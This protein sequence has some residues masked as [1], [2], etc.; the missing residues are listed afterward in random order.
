ML[1]VPHNRLRNPFISQQIIWQKLDGKTVSV[2]LGESPQPSYEWTCLAIQRIRVAS[3]RTGH[4]E[5]HAVRRA[6]VLVVRATL[7]FLRASGEGFLVLA[8]AG[9]V[10]LAAF[11]LVF[12][13]ALGFLRASG[14]G[15]IVF[16]TWVFLASPTTSTR[17]GNSS[18]GGFGVRWWPWCSDWMWAASSSVRSSV[19]ARF[20]R[21][22]SRYSGIV[23]VAMA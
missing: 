7:G 13:A 9:F 5:C 12:R 2:K 23:L 8:A 19:S 22:S 11:A 18:V 17:A 15:F 3:I 6:F 4:A 14:A 10:A 20:R 21:S 1:K 16:A